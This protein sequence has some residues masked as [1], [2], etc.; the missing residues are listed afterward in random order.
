M[1]SSHPAAIATALILKQIFKSRPQSTSDYQFI[2]DDPK[3]NL[4][5]TEPIMPMIGFP[6]EPIGRIDNGKLRFDSRA[7]ARMLDAQTNLN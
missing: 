1:I 2:A 3:L 5:P 4:F 6:K 7:I